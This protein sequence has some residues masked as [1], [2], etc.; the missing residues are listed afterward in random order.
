VILLDTHAWLWWAS[1]PERL[2]TPAR[3]AIDEADRI[4]V[5]TLSV[6]E[7]AMLTVRGRIRLDRDLRTWVRQALGQPRV[8]SVAPSPDAAIAAALLDADG[9]PGDPADRLNYATA[10]AGR[11]PLVTRDRAIRRFDAHGTVW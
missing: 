11:S 6:W 5:S 10:R 7:V 4:G 9:F 3:R 8:E 2:S 1:Q